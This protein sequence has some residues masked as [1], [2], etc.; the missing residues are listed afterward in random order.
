M[1]AGGLGNSGFPEQHGTAGVSMAEAGSAPRE[2]AAGV[3]SAGG[4][5]GHLPPGLRPPPPPPN[6]APASGVTAGAGMRPP[7]DAGAVG[8][9]TLAPPTGSTQRGR[10]SG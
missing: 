8:S 6:P 4:A 5:W 3:G 2:G 7:L 9:G 1:G 10:Y